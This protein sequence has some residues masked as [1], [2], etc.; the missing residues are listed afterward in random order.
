M[1]MRTFAAI[2]C[3]IMFSSLATAT[4]LKVTARTNPS[5]IAAGGSAV[6]D[7]KVTDGTTPKANQN[8]KLELAEGVEC[9]SVKPD[10]AAT[11]ANGNI[12]VQFYGSANVENCVA[13]IHVTAVIP[14]GDTTN[15]AEPADTMIIVNPDTAAIAKLD[16]ISVIAL[17]IVVSFAIDR[18]VRGIFFL[19]SYVGP[20][21]RAFPEPE[22]SKTKPSPRAERN[23]K[24]IYFVLSGALG[25]I[26][27]AWFGRIR[28]LAALG[29]T[30]VS[31]WLD[32]IVTGLILVGGAERTEQIL[33]GVGGGHPSAASETSKPLEITGKLIIDDQSH[34][35][36]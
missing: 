35:S 9:G 17:I 32:V 1:K 25:I 30:S 31:P 2:L 28:I 10:T 33:R 11:D 12:T 34:K 16:G 20:W 8:I 18:I 3:L 27:L 7:I 4:T 24:L 15:T 19:L 13:R 14:P 29:F 21:A 6:I 26:A 22:F 5:R 23:R 36:G